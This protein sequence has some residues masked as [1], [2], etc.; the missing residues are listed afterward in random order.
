MKKLLLIL[1]AITVFLSMFS[2]C[3]MPWN[4]KSEGYT[5]ISYEE[6][7]KMIDEQKNIIILDVRTKEEFEGGYI[8]GAV[9]FPSQEVNEET[10]AQK[11]PDKE[12]TILIYCSS[13]GRSKKVAQQLADMGYTNIYEFGGINSWPYEIYYNVEK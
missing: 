2:A 13:G 12:K 3:T 11:L 1:F 4:E 6:A 5:Q 9:L 8:K 7:K 10:A